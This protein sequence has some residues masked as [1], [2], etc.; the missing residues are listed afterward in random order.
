MNLLDGQN[1]LMARGFDYLPEP[2]LTIMLN[3]AKNAFEDEWAWPWNEVVETGPAPLGVN[4]LKHVLY[5]QDTEHDTELLGLDVRQL[6]QGG[7]PLDQ[8]GRPQYW[9]LDG[10]VGSA[11]TVTVRVWPVA[12]V[13][14]EVRATVASPELSNPQDTPLIPARYH[15]LWIDYAVLDAYRDSDNFSAAQLLQASIGARIGDLIE[16]YETRNRQHAAPIT[17]YVFSEDD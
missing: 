17:Q 5:V 6:A 13:A 2:R 14:L 11:E 15:P 16:R 3:N 10:P 1:E 12:P 9:W 4:R 7:T 8:V